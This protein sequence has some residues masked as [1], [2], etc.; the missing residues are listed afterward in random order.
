MGPINSLHDRACELYQQLV[1]IV[2][3]KEARGITGNGTD[4]ARAVYGESHYDR[5]HA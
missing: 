5:D 1:G 3:F 2:T 4:L